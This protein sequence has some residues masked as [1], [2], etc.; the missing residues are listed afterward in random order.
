MD[1]A[2]RC[3]R[4]HPFV[5]VDNLIQS[6]VLLLLLLMDWRSTMMFSVSKGMMR[7][8]THRV[9]QVVLN[10]IRTPRRKA[11]V[12]G[13][14]FV[15]FNLGLSLPAKTVRGNP[16]IFNDNNSF[17]TQRESPKPATPPQTCYHAFTLIVDR[18]NP[19]SPGN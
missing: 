15:M 4:L 1:R 11:N 2:T 10:L 7:S 12:A 16:Y 8:R 18:D 17:P 9:R 5:D 19:S 3:S 6:S 13:L 14:M